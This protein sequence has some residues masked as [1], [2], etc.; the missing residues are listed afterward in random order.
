MNNAEAGNCSF[1]MKT[2]KE[3]EH[4]VPNTKVHGPTTGG[5]TYRLVILCI[6]YVV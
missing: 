4:G 2:A 1:C 6:E 3:E 5:T